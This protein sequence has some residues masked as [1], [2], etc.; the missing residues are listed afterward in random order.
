MLNGISIVSAAIVEGNLILG[1]SD[2]SIINA[3]FV[4][5]PQGLQGPQG[6]MG[7]T[8]KQGA[9][10]NTIHGVAGSPRP[11]LGKDGDF[12]IDVKNWYIYGPKAGGAW[13]KGT[14]MLPSD[15]QLQLGTKEYGGSS[16]GGGSSQ[17]GGGPVGSVFTNNVILTAPTRSYLSSVAPMAVVK[18]PPAGMGT[19]Q[20]VNRWFFDTGG[21]W[22]HLND[23]IP[24]FVG[25]NAPTTDV[26]EGR[27]WW[28][29][30]A[31]DLSLYIYLSGDW[32]SASPPVSLNQTHL[33]LI[34]I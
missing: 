32:V 20:D 7:A 9:D 25:P 30:D 14:G 19:Q 16:A 27:L 15:R 26:Y 33:S 4:Q 22:D 29:S 12:A 24:V 1:L 11:D 2:G 3:G 13:G 6:P 34:H 28:C 8:G 21:A 10:G 23:V 31:D 5:G 18:D 17:G